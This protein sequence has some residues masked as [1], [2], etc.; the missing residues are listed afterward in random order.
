[1]LTMPLHFA[2]IATEN[3]TPSLFD[4]E[5]I[6]RPEHIQR[7]VIKRQAEFFAVRICARGQMRNLGNHHQVGAGRDGAPQWP[8]GVL[9][10]I[11]HTNKV[12]VATAL[13]AEGTGQIIRGVGIDVER[14]VH[15]RVFEEIGASVLN[16]QEQQL[17]RDVE[18]LPNGARIASGGA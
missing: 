9:G 16:S 14:I 2:A 18:A 10:S 7:S 15:S 17:I 13:R 8:L 6:N 4:N 5:G 3:F 12:A 1:M 11:T